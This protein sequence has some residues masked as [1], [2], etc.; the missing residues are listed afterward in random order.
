MRRVA[1]SGMHRFVQQ[2]GP[3][4]LYSRSIFASPVV[5]YSTRPATVRVR[6]A[7]S[8]TGYLH[9][10]G[11]RTALFNYLFAKSH[12]GDFLMRIEDT[13]QT[14][15]VEGSVEAL[16]KS[17]QWCGIHEDEG[18]T[19]GGN[20]GPYVQSER[21]HVYKS[22]ADT[23]VENGH[24][25]R[26]FCSQDRLKSLRDSAVR[27]GSG[28]MY[29]RA[30]LGLDQGQIDEKLARGD[31]HTIRLKVPEG[32]TTLK[33]LVR[34]Y[35][36]FDHSVVDDQVLM[37]S[38]GFPTYHLAHV[39]D[40]H[41]MGI[42]H[43]IRGE[44]WLSSTPKHLL[45]YKF[46]GFRLPE[47]AHLGLLLNE[48]RSKLSKRQGDVAVED[49][50]KKGFLAPALVN[51]VALLGWNP[52]DG[53]KQEIFSLDE[54]QSV[55]SMDHVNKSGSVVNI[56]RLRWINSKH[57]R[58]LFDTAD[59]ADVVATLRP[60]LVDHIHQLETFS[61]DYIWSA[62][63]L[64]KERVGALPDF[65]PLIYY[66][67]TDPDY[68]S[69]IAVEMKAKYWNE[70]TDAAVADATTRLRALAD[71]DFDSKSIMGVIKATANERNLNLKSLL[72][73][74]RYHLTGM[75][76]GAS[77]GDTMELLG[78]AVSVKRLTGAH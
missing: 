20:F 40:D 3:R 7:P 25:Y 35:V 69:T 18:P 5:Q 63:S 27:S 50:Q 44:E 58:R 45:L 2:L 75:E 62:A 38:D 66:F 22:Y 59:K 17:L 42:T 24:A 37:K 16:T 70:H 53:N 76:V 10:G 48:D 52:S 21:L 31:P 57:I 41:L 36:Q 47:F 54:L 11:L 14:R 33:D 77:I 4:S 28:T 19:A 8:P 13:D 32:K 71:S 61:D 26:C 1:T 65:G 39:V 67:F 23:L 29:D 15:K 51:F 43:V 6:Y 60:Y 30:C 68:D 73:P 74:L 55:F 72:M 12:G 64:M 9:L 46:L 34:G 49:F 78:K 56:E